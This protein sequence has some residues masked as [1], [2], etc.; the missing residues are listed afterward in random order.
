MA[1]LDGL[2]L[3]DGKVALEASIIEN[4][5]VKANY[6]YLIRAKSERGAT[7][8]VT[9]AGSV[10]PA[11]NIVNLYGLNFEGTMDFIGNY[12]MRTGMK[13]NMEKRMQGGSLSVPYND[14][15]VLLPYRWYAPLTNIAS[16][17]AIDITDGGTTAVE[18]VT[19][20]ESRQAVYDLS[21][22]RME[23]GAT[24]LPKGVY[25]IGNKKYVIK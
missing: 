22:R 24:A 15:E 2:R 5:S 1:Q 17:I 3:H 25:I 14:N 9:I 4:G 20:A 19:S 8:T 13:S 12:S 11:V 21:G 18:S 10:S 6:P 7:L 16:R 23:G